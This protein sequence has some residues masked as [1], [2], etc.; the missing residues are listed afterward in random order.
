MFISSN[1]YSLIHSDLNWNPQLGL[2]E[3]IVG[4]IILRTTTLHLGAIWAMNETKTMTQVLNNR[5]SQ[6]GLYD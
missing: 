4:K 2:S 3:Q 6:F 1:F 5:E